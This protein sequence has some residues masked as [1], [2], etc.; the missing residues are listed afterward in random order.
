MNCRG[1]VPVPGAIGKASKE[2][3]TPQPPCLSFRKKTTGG[4][5]AIAW[6]YH[7]ELP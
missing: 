4:N 7:F 1:T 5:S 3:N 2:F 6:N